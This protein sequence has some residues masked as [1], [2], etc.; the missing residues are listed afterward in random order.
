MSNW[1]T[2][3]DVSRDWDKLQEEEI[4]IEGFM[5]WVSDMLEALSCKDWSEEV[6][7]EKECIIDDLRCEAADADTDIFNELWERIYDWADQSLDGK[8]AGK[9]VCWIKTF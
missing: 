8:F 3:L 2:V 7:E 9:K 1:V 5:L 6:D 4:S